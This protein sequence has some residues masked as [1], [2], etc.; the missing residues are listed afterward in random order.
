M[1][2]SSYRALLRIPGAAPVF[3]AALVGRLSYGTVSLA[4]V[5][6]VRHSTGSY[7][8]VGAVL[9]LFGLTCAALAPVRAALIDRHGV[10]RVLPALSL[11]YGGLLLALT[12]VRGEPALLALAAAAGACAPPLGPVLRARWSELLGPH[13]LL[14]RA[15]SLDAVAEELLY[16]SGPLLVGL[17]GGAPGL[18]L[19]A[20]LVIVGALALARLAPARVTAAEPPGGAH[21]ARRGGGRLRGIG[22]PVAVAWALGLAL[23]GLSLLLVVA[24][25][26]RGQAG[27]LAWLEAAL[28]A[29]SAVGGLAHGAVRWQR[30]V[31]TRLTATAAGLGGLLALAG[32][33]VGLGGL[34]AL[35][36]AVAAVGLLVSP[37]L[38]TAYVLADERAA[39]EHRTRAGSWVNTAFNAGSALGTA[40]AGP[41]AGRWPLP[42]CFACAAAPLVLVALTPAWRGRRAAQRAAEQAA[43]TE[44]PVPTQQAAPA[45]QV[46]PTEQLAPSQQAAPAEPVPTQQAAPAQQAAPTEQAAPAQQPVPT[47]QPTPA[48]EQPVPAQV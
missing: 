48:D 21:T 15:F 40:A 11:P 7:T 42:L 22:R 29:G 47:Q 1:S 28:A 12:L 30:P 4:L 2:S 9:A 38:A 43:P 10:R 31:A 3:A 25:G 19:S 20:V 18:V 36:M 34:L 8:A 41:L 44:Q 46:E 33:A 23:G 17:I 13:G 39:A 32:V 35:A 27:A 14:E 5:L 37:T 24:V 16:V 26:A 6:T 45:E